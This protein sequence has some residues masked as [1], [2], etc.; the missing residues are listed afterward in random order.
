LRI[1]AG[2]AER[3]R[4]PTSFTQLALTSVSRNNI[5]DIGNLVKTV[6]FQPERNFWKTIPDIANW[7]NE[8][9]LENVRKAQPILPWQV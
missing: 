3:L 8:V 5:M 4:V 7:V 2:I 6:G 9:G 1:L